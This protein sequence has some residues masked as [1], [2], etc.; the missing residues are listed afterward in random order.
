ML[1][2]SGLRQ[3]TSHMP[4][5]AFTAPVDV[6][7]RVNLSSSETFADLVVALGRSLQSAR[8]HSHFPFATVA[9]EVSEDIERQ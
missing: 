3:C 1:N 2:L 9:E 6:G 7:L 4:L 5:S 8:Q